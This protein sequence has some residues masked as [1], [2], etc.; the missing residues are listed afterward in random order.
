MLPP[1][2]PTLF[3]LLKK[4]TKGNPSVSINSESIFFAFTNKAVEDVA[5]NKYNSFEKSGRLKA[6]DYVL[7][8]GLITSEEPKH[9]HN[10]KEISPTFHNNHMVEYENRIS[11]I[12]DSLL[13]NWSDEVDVRMEM[14]FFV[15]K[16]ILDIF[17]SE[18][19]DEYFTEARENVSTASYKIANSIYDYELLKSRDELREF[20]KKIVDKR[21]ESKEKKNDF[22]DIII[23]SYNNKKIDLNDLYDEAITMLLVGYETTAF[24][25]EWA[26]YYL[27]INKDWQDKISKEEDIDAFINEVLRMSPPIWNES[28]VA[29][30]DVEI[31]GTLIPTGTHVMLTSLAVHRNKDV[32]E[33]P[34]TFKPE[35]WFDNRDLSKGEYF[36]FLFGKRQCI[37]KEFA[38]MEMRVMLTKIAK[39]FSLELINKEVGHTAT[40]SYRP[41]EAIQVKVKQK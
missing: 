36:P 3:M 32:F 33:D 30:E 19:M 13:S 29:M 15:F 27:S 37:G 39:K 22:L 14:G 6:L 26:V 10:K 25:L 35:R 21:L 7:G 18:S 16:S 1:D 8:E 12:I 20:S 40:I 31:D 24:A 4:A 28:R 38:L 2:A 11:A 41:K 17:F 5:L 23:N 9:M 34:D